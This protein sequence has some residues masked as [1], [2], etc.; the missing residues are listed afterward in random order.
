MERLTKEEIDEVAL[1]YTHLQEYVHVQETTLT[2]A[3]MDE[4]AL[5]YLTLQKKANTTKKKNDVL[6]F[7]AYK[8]VCVQKFRY[9]INLHIRKYKNFANY[10]DLEQDGFEALINALNTFNPQKGSFAWWANMYIKTRVKRKANAH[11]VIRIPIK[12]ANTIKPYKTSTIPK[13][14]STIEYILTP[15]EDMELSENSQN[16]QRAIKILTDQ[17]RLVVNMK[18]GLNGIRECSVEHILEELS[19]SRSQYYKTL[20]EAKSKIKKHL[21]RAN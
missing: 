12:K 3:E 11:S 17:Q 5:K 2:K 13:T 16:L 21:L 7:E 18:Y 8:N 14:S 1:E 19:I 10:I 4:V 9:L 15:F 20:S 6:R